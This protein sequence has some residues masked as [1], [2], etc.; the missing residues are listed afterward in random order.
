MC[1]SRARRGL[2]THSSFS[3]G[4]AC[5]ALGNTIRLLKLRSLRRDDERG[6]TSEPR[7]PAFHHPTSPGSSL[8]NRADH[9]STACRGC[10]EQNISTSYEA[11][12]PVSG[13]R[14]VLLSTAAEKAFGKIAEVGVGGGGTRMRTFPNTLRCLTFLTAAEQDLPLIRTAASVT[15]QCQTHWSCSTAVNISEPSQ[16]ADLFSSRCSPS[17]QSLLVPVIALF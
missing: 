13:M 4:R 7:F 3:L 12:V 2:C 16:R 11:D 6:Q 14:L 10:C 17:R 8:I 1:L 15:L 9:E 5:T